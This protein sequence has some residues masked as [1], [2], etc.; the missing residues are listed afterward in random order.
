[1]KLIKSMML[2]KLLVLS[3][4]IVAFILSSCSATKTA[5]VSYDDFR[6][7]VDSIGRV[8]D[9]KIWTAPGDY[10]RMGMQRRFF[11]VEKEK[12][13]S[14]VKVWSRKSSLPWMVNMYRP[15]EITLSQLREG[16]SLERE[17]GRYERLESLRADKANRVAWREYKRTVRDSLPDMNLIPKRVWKK[18]Q[19]LHRELENMKLTQRSWQEQRKAGVVDTANIKELSVSRHSFN[20]ISNGM[21]G[22]AL[23]GKPYVG[24]TFGAE[25]YKLSD[26]ETLW[27]H[28]EAERIYPP[29]ECTPTCVSRDSS[30]VLVKDGVMGMTTKSYIKLID[31]HFA[32]TQNPPLRYTF[33]ENFAYNGR[34]YLVFMCEDPDKCYCRCI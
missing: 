11:D 19:M 6:S 23:S 34:W 33:T 5:N 31:C 15:N 29:T 10:Y 7:A 27:F 28:Q 25:G 4:V 3:F 13:A 20:T 26:T 9:V 32:V 24:I 2:S 16:D 12:I 14:G 30:Y 8:Y 17:I 21:I 1:M 18:R 22:A